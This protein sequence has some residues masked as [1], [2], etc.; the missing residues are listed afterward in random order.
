MVSWPPNACSSSL[1]QRQNEG[2]RNIFEQSSATTDLYGALF[3]RSIP[4][5][6][7]PK[8]PFFPRISASARPTHRS[9]S[10]MPA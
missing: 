6:R 9:R 7:K 8:S 10:T 3:A 2:S 4:M 5:E 1:A